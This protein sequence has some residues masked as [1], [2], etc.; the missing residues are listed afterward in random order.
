MTPWL[1]QEAPALLHDFFLDIW[2][3]W[4]PAVHHHL[5]LVSGGYPSA[6][7]LGDSPAR[8]GGSA[9]FTPE[10]L[11]PDLLLSAQASLPGTRPFDCV[12]SGSMGYGEPND[13]SDDL[14]AYPQPDQ[15]DPSVWATL[16]TASRDYE[17]YSGFDHAVG[18]SQYY[19]PSTSLGPIQS[20]PGYENSQISSP[21]DYLAQGNLNSCT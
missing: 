18:S 3:G 21:G 9:G 7:P 14:N 2:N 6:T 20:F 8:V 12:M 11:A 19:Q 1:T 10:P 13:D 16:A 5:D 17:D 15:L 4:P